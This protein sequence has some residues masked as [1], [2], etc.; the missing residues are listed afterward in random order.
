METEKVSSIPKLQKKCCKKDCHRHIINPKIQKKEKR[1]FVKKH[2]IVQPCKT[3]KIGERQRPRENF[4]HFYLPNK[5]GADIKV[6]KAAFLSALDISSDFVDQSVKDIDKNK[7]K[8]EYNIDNNNNNNIPDA[9]CSIP[10]TVFDLSDDEENETSTSDKLEANTNNSRLEN[11][12]SLPEIPELI[13]TKEDNDQLHTSIRLDE[14]VNQVLDTHLNVDL[15]IDEKYAGEAA[16]A[17]WNLPNEH[18][19]LIF[20][21]ISAP[22]IVKTAPLTPAV[23]MENLNINDTTNDTMIEVQKQ[24]EKLMLNINQLLPGKG[25]VKY[26]DDV[27]ENDEVEEE[28]GNKCGD[29]NNKKAKRKN[30]RFGMVD[31]NADNLK[32]EK[33]SIRENDNT[34]EQAGD[35]QKNENISKIE[36]NDYLEKQGLESGKEKDDIIG[37]KHE[38]IKEKGEKPELVTEEEEEDVDCVN[39]KEDQGAKTNDESGNTNEK[40]DSSVA[41]DHGDETYA[42]EKD[43]IQ[44]ED[45]VNKPRDHNV[46]LKDKV[47]NTIKCKTHE[48]KLETKTALPEVSE[49][50]ETF[51][52]KSAVVLNVMEDRKE[53]ENWMGSGIGWIM[54]CRRRSYQPN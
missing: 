45:E 12:N 51:P 38:S 26:T 3:K 4:R 27:Q 1:S 2:V 47:E 48:D 6:C 5:D 10:L 17:L 18:P 53:S 42:E 50:D 44:A 33:V 46:N 43:E 52:N 7:S 40:Q 11:T 34:K 8:E 15:D 22:E 30:K 25:K 20:V 13:I 39:I 41:T 32:S 14:A 9:Q 29:K 16:E 36:E 19:D 24:L 28:K 21:D 49:E 23:S 37:K 54:C 31:K 35:E